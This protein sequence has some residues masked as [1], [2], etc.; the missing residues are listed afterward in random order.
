MASFDLIRDGGFTNIYD[1]FKSEF[2]KS[3]L[4]KQ[5]S[6]NNDKLYEQIIKDM[7][8]SWKQV[9]NGIKFNFDINNLQMNES[10]KSEK[11]KLIDEYSREE[12]EKILTYSSEFISDEYKLNIFKF[13]LIQSDLASNLEYF[14][15]NIGK[16]K[17]SI[18][19]KYDNKKSIKYIYL[20]NNNIIIE[21]ELVFP[22]LLK[23]E[24]GCILNC[25]IDGKDIGV[26]GSICF[27]KYINFNE[28]KVILTLKDLIITQSEEDIKN[29]QIEGLSI[30]DL[31]LF[32]KQINS[33]NNSQMID[34]TFYKIINLNLEHININEINNTG[35]INTKLTAKINNNQSN[36]S[37]FTYKINNVEFQ[38]IREISSEGMLNKNM[39]LFQYKSNILFLFSSYEV[40]LSL[41]NISRKIFNYYFQ[42]KSK[43]G[44]STEVGENFVNIGN[45]E[46]S[47]PFILSLNDNKK[48]K[49]LF[50]K[51]N[52]IFITEYYFD[53]IFINPENGNK[54]II[55]QVYT[56]NIANLTDNTYKMYFHVNKINALN[57][58]NIK[59]YKNE[60]LN[61]ILDNI[62]NIYDIHNSN[63]ITKFNN[64][65]EKINCNQ[66]SSDKLFLKN[67]IKTLPN[68]NKNNINIKESD[69]MLIS[70]NENKRTD[71]N[72]NDCLP[73]I[74]KI[75]MNKPK[76]I[77]VCTQECQEN[78]SN[79]AK[80]LMSGL[81]SER[82]YQ[83]I[84]GNIVQSLDYKLISKQ[85]HNTRNR[86][87]KTFKKLVSRF[88]TLNVN[89]TKVYCL[90]D[91]NI[92]MKEEKKDDYTFSTIN[93]SFLENSYNIAILNCNLLGTM[94]ESESNFRT[95]VSE[96]RLEELN[97]DHD[98]FFCG[99]INFKFW[100]NS[101]SIKSR[102]VLKKKYLNKSRNLFN[103]ALQSHNYKSNIFYSNLVKSIKE[104]GRY[105]TS[106][107]ISG[108]YRREIEL[109]ER[110]YEA[111]LGKAGNGNSMN[112]VNSN[113]D[114]FNANNKPIL[115][116]NNSN[117]FQ[118]DADR[119]LYT[120][121]PESL[122]RINGKN[123]NV[124]FFPDKS[125][126][127]LLS[128]T[129]N[130]N[131]NKNFH[132]HMTNE[133]P[134]L[135]YANASPNAAMPFGGVGNNN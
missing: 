17:Y 88:A 18:S 40:N 71:Y 58:I 32:Q 19:T 83:I 31:Y 4:L 38:D 50:T 9:I 29:L 44:N 130:L 67:I 52:F 102:E 20:C 2:H 69:V 84:F 78:P 116:I 93:F 65:L 8:R 62:I 30:K 1:Y 131:S 96:N 100:C 82:T 46:N 61:G 114:E 125:S 105:L 85:A 92:K 12:Y 73:I 109:Y 51:D 98:I 97:E 121:K 118:I 99:N 72:Y 108:Q 79:A 128:L 91:I 135:L 48:E 127:K 87:T 25:I 3:N 60:L 6:V 10:E 21:S 111:N 110:F 101:N 81:M 124:H 43:V 95:I 55:G 23:N 68:L 42:K 122:I 11:E 86:V 54:I 28:N 56:Y 5:N 63:L 103:M 90:K 22:I 129:F 53:I 49:N 64:I 132:Q 115:N 26:I 112:S 57:I 133:D 117:P 119:I 16:E 126:H 80:S 37:N 74:N 107:Y 13:N 41:Q 106:G 76:I 123:F 94:Q 39:P 104:L 47:S 66:I 75:L 59:C 27:R 89:K 36:L 7:K 77:I 45:N 113:L 34:Y 35:N 14:W 15:I 120:L 24:N 33:Q 70:F 134:L